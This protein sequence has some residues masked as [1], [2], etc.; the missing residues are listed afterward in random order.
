MATIV[1]VQAGDSGAA[2]RGKINNNFINLANESI[3]ASGF[4]ILTDTSG[5]ANTITAAY[6]GY[7]AY[8]D[9]D[10]FNLKIANAN[11]G[12]VT[13]NIES[14][15]AKSVKVNQNDLTTGMLQANSY[16]LI[17]YNS[18]L[19]YFEL[20]SAYEETNNLVT[21]SGTTKTL[22]LSDAGTYQ[23]CTNATGTT[24]TVPPNSSVAFPIGTEIIFEQNGAGTITFVAGSGVTIN[25]VDSNLDIGNQ[26]GTVALKKKATD[27]WTLFGDLA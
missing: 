9:N 21:V 14:L 19:G 18:T 3:N 23:D 1:T 13:I 22:A 16:Y 24:I 8:A 15:G 20:L 25:S 27:T 6:S 12:A 17:V 7:T 5:A 4:V 26:Y 11:T 2:A 10:K